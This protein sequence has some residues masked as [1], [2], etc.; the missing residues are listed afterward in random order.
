LEDRQ[1]GCGGDEG[2]SEGVGFEGEVEGKRPESTKGTPCLFYSY[3]VIIKRKL[4]HLV[5]KI[6]FKY[7]II[8]NNIIQ[9]H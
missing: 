5:T 8:P 7:N 9:T 2:E 4:Q 3:F 1:V 6:C